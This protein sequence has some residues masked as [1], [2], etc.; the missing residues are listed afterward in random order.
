M[1]SLEYIVSIGYIL[2]RY[3]TYHGF[4]GAW[5][6][7]QGRYALPNLD[8]PGG[9]GY[10]SGLYQ[11]VWRKMGAG[12]NSNP[13]NNFSDYTSVTGPD[14]QTTYVLNKYIDQ[15]V[16]NYIVQNILLQLQGDFY[17]DVAYKDGS[18]VRIFFED[19][20]AEF[21][22]GADII[23]TGALQSVLA[24]GNDP[25]GQGGPGWEPIVGTAGAIAG[26][27][28]YSKTYGTW[29]GKN[30]KMYQ[31]T[32][33]GNGATGGKLKFGKKVSTGIKIGGYGLGVWNAYKIDQQNRTGQ[34]T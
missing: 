16:S 12:G 33:G 11:G 8:G 30:F 22:I 25:S 20:V 5:S 18:E 28:Y 4:A 21:N 10:G 7:V 2:D 34:I 9:G 3:D 23:K 31:Q 32:W 13:G 14:G 1:S 6:S 27:M 26:E 29:M 15:V 24:D 19:A 17:I